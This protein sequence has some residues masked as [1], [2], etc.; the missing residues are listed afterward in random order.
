MD[1]ALVITHH[2]NRSA[3]IVFEPDYFAFYHSANGRAREPSTSSSETL[4]ISRGPER[5]LNTR[6]RNLEHILS[7]EQRARV[8]ARL[9]GARRAGAIVHG[10]FLSITPIDANVE[11]WPRPRPT[12]P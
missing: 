7:L 12:T 4:P 2:G 5:S 11:H 9:D 3:S 1:H 8:E 6:R 10:H